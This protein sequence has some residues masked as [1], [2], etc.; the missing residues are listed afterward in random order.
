M[1]LNTQTQGNMLLRLP[2]TYRR[3]LKKKTNAQLLKHPPIFQPSH[4]STSILKKL[5]FMNIIILFFL[6]QYLL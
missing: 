6:D 1:S 2:N 4:T 3:T 5:S